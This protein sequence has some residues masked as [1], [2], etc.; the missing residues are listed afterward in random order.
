MLRKQRLVAEVNDLTG[1]AADVSRSE[2]LEMAIIL[3]IVF[4]LVAA[5]R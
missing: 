4:E 5:L 1:D 3:L 2:L